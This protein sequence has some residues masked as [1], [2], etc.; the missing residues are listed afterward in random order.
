M[1]CYRK[2]ETEK[3]K[4]SSTSTHA[5]QEQEKNSS[6]LLGVAQN[7]DDRVAAQEHFRNEPVP[8]DPHPLL[9]AFRSCSRSRSA[10]SCF[11]RV[12]PHL[13]DVLEDHVAMAVEG[14]GVN[15]GVAGR[16]G[17]SRLR[18][19]RRVFSFSSSLR[20]GDLNSLSLLSPFPSPFP[21]PLIPHL[22]S[23]QKLVVVAQI[24][25]HLCACFVERGREREC[26]RA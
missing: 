11:R 19:R 24:D 9:L 14:L 16:G 15:G 13:L 1:F 7:Q 20:S 10:S 8:G 2:S 3:V 4:T 18:K 21:L 25:E 12:G 5:R 17:R 23:C 22:D 6:N 26:R